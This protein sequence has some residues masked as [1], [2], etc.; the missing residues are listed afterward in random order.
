VNAGAFSIKTIGIRHNSGFLAA[1]SEY[2]LICDSERNW[3]LPLGAIRWSSMPTSRFDRSSTLQGRRQCPRRRWRLLVL[4]SFERW[5]SVGKFSSSGRFQWAELC[6]WDW[7]DGC[8]TSQLLSQV[9]VSV[10]ETEEGLLQLLMSSPSSLQLSEW[11]SVNLNDAYHPSW[12]Y[13]SRMCLEN[14][15][16]KRGQCRASFY[17][18]MVVLYFL[19]AI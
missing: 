19:F 2:G 1:K 16:M 5:R 14:W 15:K 6:R 4:S 13:T 3:S 8:W 12:R 18:T 7:F 17:D 9:H 10:N 11:L